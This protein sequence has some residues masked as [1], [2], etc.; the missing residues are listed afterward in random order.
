MNYRYHTTL[1][2]YEKTPAHFYT[3]VMYASFSMRMLQIIDPYGADPGLRLGIGI[4]MA[5]DFI[6][7][8]FQFVY[9]H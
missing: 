7:A 5:V 2:P 1:V 4:E 6:F 8:E 9:F 3:H